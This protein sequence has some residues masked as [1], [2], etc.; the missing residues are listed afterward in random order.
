MV[1]SESDSEQ[2]VHI[3]VAYIGKKMESSHTSNLKAHQ[4][5]LE[6]KQEIT[7][8]RNRQQEI[9]KCRAKINKIDTKS[10]TKNQ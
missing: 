8:K 2:Q 4:K 9:V 7:S 3:V 6:Q 10:K 1:F 5:V